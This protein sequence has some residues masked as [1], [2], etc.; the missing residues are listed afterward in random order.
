MW[1]CK[2]V[3]MTLRIVIICS[4][5]FNLFLFRDFN[6]KSRFLSLRIRY[7]WEIKV[8]LWNCWQTL[9]RFILDFTLMHS[10]DAK[11]V[12]ICYCFINFIL[13][14]ILTMTIKKTN[15]L[16]LGHLHDF[17]HLQDF[18]MT[19]EENILLIIFL[20]VKIDIIQ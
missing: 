13:M 19:C 3:L 15:I 18:V 17:S 14:L 6:Y 11:M 8:T 12:F 10:S 20:Q 2:I 5:E 1:F 7:I 9:K 16:A 4:H